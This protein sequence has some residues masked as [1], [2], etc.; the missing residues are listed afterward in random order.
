M[1][2]TNVDVAMAVQE[3]LARY[4]RL[5]DDRRLDDCAAL[6]SDEAVLVVNGQKHEGRSAIRT[7]MAEIGRNPGGRHLT[8][9][10]VLDEASPDRA[11][12]VSDLAHLRRGPAGRWELSAVGRYIDDMAAINDTWVFTRRQIDID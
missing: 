3:L 7:W 12:G 11:S 1:A 5:I 4:A 9:N 10:T 8:M 2:T 6:F